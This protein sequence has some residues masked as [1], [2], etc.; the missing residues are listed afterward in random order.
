[1]NHNHLAF[2]RKRKQKTKNQKIRGTHTHER[3]RERQRP[4][5]FFISSRLLLRWRAQSAMVVQPSESGRGSTGSPMI[6]IRR[7][8]SEKLL[9]LKAKPKS[10]SEAE[11]TRDHSDSITITGS[12]RSE[13]KSFISLQTHDL[14][15]P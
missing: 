12:N 2:T 5:S 14:L 7:I 11:P 4:F 15:Q 10:A 3:K 9:S 8:R 1:M 13:F 6:S